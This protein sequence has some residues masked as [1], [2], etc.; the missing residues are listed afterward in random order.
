MMRARMLIRHKDG[1]TEFYAEPG[2]WSNRGLPYVFRNEFHAI[3][4]VQDDEWNYEVKV[5]DINFY[6]RIQTS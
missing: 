6:E 4:Y 5:Y 1:V 3:R 2:Q